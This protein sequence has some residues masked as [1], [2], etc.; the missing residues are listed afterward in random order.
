VVTK[1]LVNI[2]R[3]P[4]APIAVRFY[5]PTVKLASVSAVFPAWSV[6]TTFNVCPLV[7]A[8][9]TTPKGATL[10]SP[11]LNVVYIKIHFCKK[12]VAGLGLQRHLRFLRRADGWP[13]CG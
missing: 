4:P 13:A 12:C 1:I 6:A 9:Q 5:F 3:Q 8:V 7:L 2:S 11:H 10:D